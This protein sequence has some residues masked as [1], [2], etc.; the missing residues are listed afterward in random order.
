[1]V[2][3]GAAQP[4]RRLRPSWLE[5]DLDA[6]R[7]NLAH[8]RGLVGPARTLYAVVKADGYGFGAEAMGRAF[9]EAGA[10]A[11]A[12]ADGAEGV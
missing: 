2:L 5:V 8:V 6:A 3:I 10:D 12:V 7:A 4:M 11:L 1:M 9:L